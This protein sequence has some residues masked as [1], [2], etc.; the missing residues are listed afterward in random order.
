MGQWEE[1]LELAPE[2]EQSLP[3]R[4]EEG[5]GKGH[6]GNWKCQG[7]PQSVGTEDGTGEDTWTGKLA[8]AAPGEA[9]FH[10]QYVPYSGQF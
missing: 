3:S 9:V 8:L 10:V 2:R 1:T 7:Q 4:Q 5:H 6:S